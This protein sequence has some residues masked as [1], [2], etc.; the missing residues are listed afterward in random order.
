MCD[1]F[2]FVSDNGIANYADDNTPHATNKYLETILKDLQQGSDTLLKWF[3]DN[4]L[5]TNPE[6]YYLLVSINKKRHLNVGGGNK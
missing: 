1:L 3:T 4:V 2:L 6:Q 5:N